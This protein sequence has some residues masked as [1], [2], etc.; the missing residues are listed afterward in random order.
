ML[1]V[2][3][4]FQI[5]E[6]PIRRCDKDYWEFKGVMQVIEDKML[7]ELDAVCYRSIDHFHRPVEYCRIPLYVIECKQLK[8][9]CA[10]CIYA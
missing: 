6:A 3:G 9:P 7:T 5:A 8:S 4:R 10:E 1:E 2:D